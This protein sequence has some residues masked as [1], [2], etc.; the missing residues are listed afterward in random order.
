MQGH[1]LF[2]GDSEI[3]QIFRIFRFVSLTLLLLSTSYSMSRLI[4]LCRL[5]G[6]PNED[7][8]PGVSSLPD[9]KTTFPQWSRKDI[10]E[11]VPQ[12]D[13]YGLDLLKLLLVYDT[14]K[15]ISGQ[16]CLEPSILR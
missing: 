4:F 14:S 9:Y 11:A 7:V 1:P 12:L 15:R 6:T 2:P 10:G 13:P 3:D 8:W 5:L 16:S